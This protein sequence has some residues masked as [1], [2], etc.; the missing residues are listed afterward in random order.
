MTV[1]IVAGPV[2][3]T[4]QTRLL[5]LAIAI[6]LPLAFGTYQR[7]VPAPDR[8]TITSSAGERLVMAPFSAPDN[9]SY[10]FRDVQPGSSEPVAFDPCRPVHFVIRAEGAPS[11]GPELI[12]SS[13]ADISAATGLMFI[14]DGFTNETPS[15]SRGNFLPDQYGD[16]WAPVLIAWSTPQEFSPLAGEVIGV[17]GNQP[18][19]AD[20]G[21]RVLVSGQVVLDAEQISEVLRYVSGRAVAVATITHELGHLVGLSHVDDP[22]QLMYPSARPLVSNLGRGDLS[23][24]A[25]LGAGR[26]FA[27]L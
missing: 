23:G 1:S 20:D 4:R 14:D 22:Q 21:Q 5:V 25:A 6:A 2:A 8:P 26:C 7:L 13:L 12:S 9:P 11:G 18:V 15:P 24:L 19:V 17:A 27:D 10:Q 16:R 3:P